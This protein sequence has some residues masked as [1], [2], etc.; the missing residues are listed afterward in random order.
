MGY[1]WKNEE[2]EKIWNAGRSAIALTTHIS[3][4]L[5]NFFSK[6][7]CSLFFYNIQLT[8]VSYRKDH[9]IYSRMNFQR[10]LCVTWCV[11]VCVKCCCFFSHLNTVTLNGIS[12]LSRESKQI[13][14]L[15]V[16]N[17]FVVLFCRATHF[18]QL[19]PFKHPLHFPARVCSML[20]AY[21]RLV[22]MVRHI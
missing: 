15:W 21:R 9:H 3:F 18:I 1:L 13:E 4:S 5:Y 11:C 10:I 7:K 22:D 20:F 16:H 14:C 12:L 2:E 8:L 6:T 17:S 19:Y